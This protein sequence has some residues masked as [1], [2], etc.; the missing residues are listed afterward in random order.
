MLQKIATSDRIVYTASIG[1]A[2]LCCI[3]IATENFWILGL[4]IAVAVVLMAV[5]R[6]DLMMLFCVI[7]TP[8]SIN[9]QETPLGIGVSLPSEPLMFGL[10]LLFLASQLHKG[11]LDRKLL[12]HPI[13]I[14]ILLHLAWMIITSMTSTML[15]VSVK[16][17]LARICFVTVFFYLVGTYFRQTKN[18]KSFIWCY[19]VP[20]LVVI[21]YTTAAHA[22][23]GFTERAAHTVMKPFY[24]DHTAYAAVIAMF[25]PIMIAFIDD[26]AAS[27]N[28]RTFAVI[29]L[30]MLVLAIVLSYT[31]AAWVSLV[32]AF[33]CYGVIALRIKTSLVVAGAVA[34]IGIV[35]FNWTA[36]TMELERNEEQSSSDYAS[37]VQSVSNIT[38]DASNVERIN[39]WGSAIRMFEEKPFLGWGPG[40]YMFQY[41][42]FQKFS[43]RTI[44]STNFGEGGN[45]HSEYIG[46][47]AEQGILG[48]L[49]F[50]ALGIASVYYASR[51]IIR[52]KNRQVRLLAKGILFGLITYLV[53]GFLNNFLDTE[54]ASVPFWGFVAAIVALDIY[55]SRMEE[56]DTAI[57]VDSGETN[58]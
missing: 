16:A 33:L 50:I 6:L 56:K 30:C 46:P 21:I 35:L 18:I 22:S 1:F 24:N 57:E 10:M 7:L 45:A 28:A 49:L 41:A 27:K 19:C 13:S 29:T 15:D 42:P 51:I 37:H 39:R 47:M 52:S 12:F 17:T 38:T 34:F 20:L 26:R 44:I 14:L 25:V 32:A 36:I 2:L 40:T 3:G 54:K 43:E 4:P 8:L 11:D 31:R 55:S 53:H 23:A 58:A 5:Y 9:L 48:S